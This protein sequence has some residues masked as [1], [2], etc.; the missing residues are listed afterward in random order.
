VQETTRPG[1]TDS[2]CAC[3]F[4]DGRRAHHD[5]LLRAPH[6]V[7][8]TVALLELATSWGE[9]DYSG[10]ALI[11]PADWLRFAAEHTWPKPELAQ[12]TFSVAVDVA[13]RGAQLSR[14]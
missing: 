11:P 5:E 8:M 12:R 14:C 6:E 3:R 1:R 10:E 4:F 7:A 13:R 9:I 2:I